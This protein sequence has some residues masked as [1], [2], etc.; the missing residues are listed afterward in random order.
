[1]LLLAPGS[2]PVSSLADARLARAV[3]ERVA[4][5]PIVR[6]MSLV[7]ELRLAGT[8]QRYLVLARHQP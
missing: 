3:E 2:G 1:M 7:A 8:E 4:A 5:F 6:A